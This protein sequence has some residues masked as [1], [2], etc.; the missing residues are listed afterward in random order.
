MMKR[1][2]AAFCVVLLLT[3]CDHV[4]RVDPTTESH[5]LDEINESTAGRWVTIDLVGGGQRYVAGFRIEGA[6]AS[7]TDYREPSGISTVPIS[8]IKAVRVQV[9][10]GGLGRI[11]AGAGLGLVVGMMVGTMLASNVPEPDPDEPFGELDQD[12]E[13]SGVTLSATL[14]GG[15]AG[16]IVGANLAHEKVFELTDEVGSSLREGEADQDPRED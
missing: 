9:A 13:R 15:L 11:L 1:A 8:D 7:W 3:G 12:L 5:A 2:V 4:R 10:T 6:A 16:A 14:V